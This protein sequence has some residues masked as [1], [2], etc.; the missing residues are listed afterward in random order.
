MTGITKPLLTAD[1]IFR[2]RMSRVSSSS[3]TFGSQSPTLLKGTATRPSRSCTAN[4]KVGGNNSG[5]TELQ[6]RS[7]IFAPDGTWTCHPNM[8]L[9]FSTSETPCTISCQASC[10]LSR[11]QQ[12]RNVQRHCPQGKQ[13]VSTTA[14]CTTPS[15]PINSKGLNLANRLLLILSQEGIARAEFTHKPNQLQMVHRG[16]M[17]TPPMPPNLLSLHRQT[18][19]NMKNISPVWLWPVWKRTAFSR[20]PFPN[21]LL[22]HLGLCFSLTRFPGRD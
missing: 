19:M 5:S 9:S 18:S 17:W 14:S 15:N 4:V 20:P 8:Q 12:S 1:E 11:L 10:S 6:G 7:S 21:Q 13:R 3:C 2:W 22:W 16:Q